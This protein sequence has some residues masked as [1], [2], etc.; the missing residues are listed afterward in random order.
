M[1]QIIAGEKGKG[2]TKHLIDR[3]N[4]AVESSTGNVIFLDKSTRHMYEVSNK[5]RLINVT[6]YPFITNE[7]FVGFLYGILSQDH[8]IEDVFIDSFLKVANVDETNISHTIEEISNI[9]KLYNIN[10]TLSVSFNEEKLPD[11]VKEY[12]VVSL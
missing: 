8:D 2:K 4:K 7:G 1:I 3:V 10:F 11:D 12:V 9:S 5:V 6:D